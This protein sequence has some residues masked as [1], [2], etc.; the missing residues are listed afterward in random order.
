M[1]FLSD[2]HFFRQ[3]RLPAL[4]TSLRER[5]QAEAVRAGED[6]DGPEGR[7]AQF[8][9]FEDLVLPELT[10]QQIA[11]IGMKSLAGDGFVANRHP[12]RNR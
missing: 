11:P 4:E 3:M 5:A 12:I 7:G 6:P 10:R 9:S 1:D 2:P 8:R